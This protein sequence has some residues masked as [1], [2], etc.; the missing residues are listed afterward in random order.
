MTTTLPFPTTTL[1]PWANE[2]RPTQIEA[3]DQ[4][5][6]QFNS[7][8]SI[9]FLEAPT[10]TGK[11]LIADVVR[12]ELRSR[13]VYLCSS[14]SLQDQFT[15]D[16]PEAAVLKGRSNYPTLDYPSRYLPSNPALGLSCADCTKHRVGD[17]IRCDWCSSVP[18]CPY[19]S[20]KIAALRADLV[21][22]NSYYFLYEANYVGSLSH[23]DLIIID[24]V[25]TIESILMSFV[26][27]NI[28]ERRIQEF[29]LP[30][31]E[32]KTV[33]S[34]WLPW[35]EEAL[36][37][38]KKQVL[39]SRQLSLFDT[40]DLK[41]IRK[42]KR[43]DGLVSDLRRLVNPDSGLATDNWVYDGYNN[44]NIIFKP[45]TIAPYAE[46]FL[47]RHGKR[48]LCMSATIISTT[49]LVESLGL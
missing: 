35:A 11:T 8:D 26:E 2:L 3:I 13:S 29:N 44:N 36:D 21:C 40:P 9:V 47:W 5:L 45:I 46:E 38:A 34:T 28:S 17:T 33:S 15:K 27:V 12:Q 31:P 39:N 25:D 4:I 30:K 22:A 42:G 48:F 18:N 16:F 20:A 49:E 32:K 6:H 19:E 43:L 14:L 37:I 24:E 10:G 41:N 7:G 23:R 1:P